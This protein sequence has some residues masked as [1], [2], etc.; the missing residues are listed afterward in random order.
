MQVKKIYLFFLIIAAI[1]LLYF[2]I[3]NWVSIKNILSPFFIAGLVAYLLNPMVK[4]FN[5]K[6][7][8]TFFS[9]LLVFLIVTL[10]IL[11]FSFYIFPLMINEMIA[12]ITM[13]PFYIEELQNILIQLKFNYFSYLPPQFEKVLD[14]NLNTLNNLFASRVDMAFKSTV[15]ILKNVIDAILVPIITFYFLKDKNLF[16]K[17]IEK[18]IPSKY[19]S[20]FFTLL[21]K[22]DKILSKYIRAQIYLSIFVGILTSIGLS[23][24]KIKYAFLVGLLTGVLNIIPYIGPILS[25][26]PAVLLG[27][28]DSLSKGIWALVVCLLVQQIE[29]AFIT[30]KILSDSVGLHPITVIFSLIAGGELF[31]IWGLLL[32]V[33]IVAIVKAVVTEIFIEK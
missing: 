16:K 27:F 9:I 30:P 19:H 25:I 11:I 22:I 8:S 18:I 7:L 4:F 24:I 20:S 2:F 10:G 6:G 29:N 1:G 21:R 32:S 31:G 3:K 12:F 5:S 14:K 13:I 26:I 23:L 33:P 28:L 17:E 15:A